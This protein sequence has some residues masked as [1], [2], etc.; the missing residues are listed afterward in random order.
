MHLEIIEPLSNMKLK[1]LNIIFCL[2]VA[3]CGISSCLDSDVVEYEYSSNASITAFSITDS[4]ITSYA[5][6][7][8]GSDT[9]LTTAVVGT[10][11]PFVINQKEGLIY[12][13]DSLP[14]GTDVSKVVVSITADT[15]GIYVVAET[16][17]LWESTDSLNFEKPVQFKV[18][19]EMG[20]FG[21]TYTAKINVHL[22]DPDSL[23]WQRIGSNFSQNI[24]KQKAVYANKT[25]Y[26]FAAAEEGVSVTMTSDTDGSVWTEPTSTN[27]PVGADYASAMAWGDQLY[28]LADNE[29]YTSTN[30]LSWEKAATDQRIAQL[31]ANTHTAYHQKIMGI[32]TDRYYIES[33]D[34]ISWNRYEKMPDEFPVL[35]YAFASYA[36]NTNEKFSRIVLM[37]CPNEATD[38]LASVWTQVNTESYWTELLMDNNSYACP[39]FE[40]HGLIHYN[41]NLY[42]FGGPGQNNGSIEAFS[43]IYTSIDNG[44]SWEAITAKF[45]FPAEFNTLYE[46]AE[47]NYSYIVDDQ[48]FIWMM[49]SQ[50]GEVWRGRLNKLGFDK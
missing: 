5:A 9:I 46:E 25:I 32:D 10:D 23:T 19:S 49:W 26:V 6:V 29:L 3:A 36:L 40:N 41:N 11:Y 16:D 34:G 44:I 37:G 8:D 42:A 22:Q 12:N 21:R 4:I 43:T 39:H 30:G 33:E 28:I 27:L 17:T 13:P 15:E 24:Q 1:V 35:N 38:T 18:V 47:G 2:F 45:M 48:Q 14:V 20:T 31:V 50:T 7:V